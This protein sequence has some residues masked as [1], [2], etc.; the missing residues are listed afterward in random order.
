MRRTEQQHRGFQLF[1]ILLKQVQLGLDIRRL[2][3]TRL[4]IYRQPFQL[5]FGLVQSL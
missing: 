2:R 1:Q 4:R 5:L 3:L